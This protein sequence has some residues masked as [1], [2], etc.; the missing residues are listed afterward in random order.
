VF[1][2]WLLTVTGNDYP[3]L[4]VVSAGFVAVGAFFVLPIR[5]AR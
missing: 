1:A 5:S 2:A 3:L 4:F